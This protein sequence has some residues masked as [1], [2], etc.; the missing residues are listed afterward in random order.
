MLSRAQVVDLDV[1]R[2]GHYSQGWALSDDEGAP[3][4]L[5]GHT[6]AAV[7]QTAAGT[8]PVIASAAIDLY[9]A[10]NGRF[11]MTWT[12]AAF[13]A[14]PGTTEIVR[15]S[16]KLRDRHPDGKTFD[17]VR[18]EIILFPENS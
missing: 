2:D 14:V 9:D 10:A 18:G 8:D 5:T 4:N 1:P 15:L 12:G 13:V 7:A 6:I 11:T 3:L 17:I 16:W